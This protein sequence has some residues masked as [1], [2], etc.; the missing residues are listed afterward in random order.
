MRP[1]TPSANFPWLARAVALKAKAAVG[2]INHWAE[3]NRAPDRVVRILKSGSIPAGT[4]TVSDWAAAATGDYG[5]S[6]NAFFESLRTTSVFF[7]LLAD[8]A[9]RIVPLHQR[10]GIIS[11]SASGWIV[12][13]G[14]PVPLSKLELRNGVLE[15]VRA[16]AQIVLTDELWRNVSTAG[17][18]AFAKELKGA[19]SDTVDRTFVDLI[20]DPSTDGSVVFNFAG[21]DNDD[22]YA[23]LRRAL[24]AVGSGS[25]SSLYWIAGTN[26]AKRASCLGPSMFE[27]MSP[28]GGEMANLPCLVSSA[29]DPDTLYLIDASR[30][31]ADAL[32]IELR[33]SSHASI[34]ME[35]SPDHDA[36]SGTE[37]TLVSMFQVGAT[38][39]QATVLFGAEPTA[40]DC[41]AVIENVQWGGE[42]T[43]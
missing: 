6:V 33:A 12:G 20:V 25:G 41:V 36:T 10:V 26:V 23:D 3:M 29:I 38:A 32:T 15:P 31:A 13:E 7:R 14:K 22:V 8:R 11:G 43:S 28:L 5:A 1:E 30:I 42:V 40:A 24:F 17:Q 34:E 16:A 19:V 21:S 4:T 9:L 39:L 18:V 27:A 37:A 35:S 2:E